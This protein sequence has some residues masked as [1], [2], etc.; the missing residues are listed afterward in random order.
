MKRDNYYSAESAT[1][2]D[3]A[4]QRKSRIEPWR[5]ELQGF[6]SRKSRVHPACKHAGQAAEPGLRRFAYFSDRDFWFELVKACDFFIALVGD[7]TVNYLARSGDR[8]ELS[9]AG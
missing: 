7:L 8:R 6:N 3:S 9:R 2:A 4:L 5:N 1:D